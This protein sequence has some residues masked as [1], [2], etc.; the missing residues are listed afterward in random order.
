[1]AKLRETHMTKKLLLILIPLLLL[2]TGCQRTN[3]DQ[4]QAIQKQQVQ[5]NELAQRLNFVTATKTKGNGE[6]EMANNHQM[7][8]TECKD[9]YEQKATTVDRI[10]QSTTSISKEQAQSIGQRAGIVDADGYVIDK[11]VWVKNCIDT[12]NNLMTSPPHETTQQGS[13]VIP[14]SAALADSFEQTKQNSSIGGIAELSCFPQSRF[15]CTTDGCKPYV[16]ATFYFVD[17][18]VDRGTYFRCDAKGCDPYPVTVTQSGIY[19]Q[20][21]PNG[22]QA[23][24]FKVTSS[25]EVGTKA[26]FVDVA[27]MGTGTI[28]SFGKCN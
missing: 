12:K 10:V 28:V 21:S 14:P 25:D 24:L 6:T 3:T 7:H 18:G 4:T 13:A 19:T 9:E 22:G 8:R 23:M 2:G 5:I 11:D 26:E 27:T 16:P 1:M 17:Y 15:N 20:F